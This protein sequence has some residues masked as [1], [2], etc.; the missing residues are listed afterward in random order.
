VEGVLGGWVLDGCVRK[1]CAL[2]WVYMQRLRVCECV[3]VCV[4]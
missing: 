1:K 3:Y 4:W 2:C